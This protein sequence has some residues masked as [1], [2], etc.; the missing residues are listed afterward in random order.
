MCSPQKLD[1]PAD[2]LE[3]EFYSRKNIDQQLF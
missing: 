3:A 1:N 2:H